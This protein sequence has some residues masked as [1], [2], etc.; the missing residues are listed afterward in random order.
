[1]PMLLR[2]A[3]VAEVPPGTS[4]VVKTRRATLVISNEGG[5]FHAVLK[6]GARAGGAGFRTEVRGDFVYVAM[7]ADRESAPADIANNMRD[8]E[9]VG[10]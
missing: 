1:M 3:H 4:R 8:P 5:V 2:V 9:T 7:D 6:S 10:R